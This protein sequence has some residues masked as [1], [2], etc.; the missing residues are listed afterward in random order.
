MWGMEFERGN[1]LK[2]LSFLAGTSA[3]RGEVATP[4]IVKR[5]SSTVNVLKDGWHRP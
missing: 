3:E 5:V 2:T 1:K 4:D